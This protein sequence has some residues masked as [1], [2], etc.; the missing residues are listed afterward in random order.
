MSILPDSS[1]PHCHLTRQVE[2]LCHVIKTA[3]A[4]DVAGVAYDTLL[5]KMASANPHDVDCERDADDWMVDLHYALQMI[6]SPVPSKWGNAAPY[7]LE[8][9]WG[10]VAW[11]QVFGRADDYNAEAPAVTFFL[12]N[13]LHRI[14]EILQWY[15]FR[16]DPR[17]VRIER[18]YVD[19]KAAVKHLPSIN[20]VE[21]PKRRH[22][23]RGPKPATPAI[24]AAERAVFKRWTEYRDDTGPDKIEFLNR[25]KAWIKSKLTRGEDKDFT[26]LDLCKLIDRVNK[27]NKRTIESD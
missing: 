17:A 18:A 6:L 10:L 1:N 19:L 11:L 27:R 8:T 16:R 3:I 24:Q 26:Y 25:D 15:E 12:H 23:R 9:Q 14:P 22:S 4:I 2:Q 5:H 13:V 21:A 20:A 7:C